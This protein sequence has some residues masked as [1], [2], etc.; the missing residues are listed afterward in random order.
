MLTQT[1][2]HKRAHMYTNAYSG[3]C[4]HAY[5]THTFTT[6]HAN[7]HTHTQNHLTT[8]IGH[9]SLDTAVQ[10][11]LSV[12][13]VWNVPVVHFYVATEMA[14]MHKARF[15]HSADVRLLASVSAHVNLQ[16]GSCGTSV[17]ALVTRK[18]LLASVSAH[19][20]IQTACS[21]ACV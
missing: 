6:I 11:K 4:E 2:A 9:T 15:T 10:C 18:W 5:I 3:S 19:V 20:T 12:V 16:M 13:H 21:N 14:G 7:A 8:H 17:N 1:H